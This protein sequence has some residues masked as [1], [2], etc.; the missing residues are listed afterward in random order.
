MQLATHNNSAVTSALAGI[1][2]V[3]AGL[4]IG[5]RFRQSDPRRDDC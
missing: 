3:L 1:G 5:L 2:L 4:G